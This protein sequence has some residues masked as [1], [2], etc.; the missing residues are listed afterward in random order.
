MKVPWRRC[1]GPADTLA[2]YF[3]DLFSCDDASSFELWTKNSFVDERHH[4]EM[5]TYTH[6]QDS[7]FTVPPRAHPSAGS[8]SGSVRLSRSNFT[9]KVEGTPTS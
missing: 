7:Y 6:S 2:L 1:R 3:R 9:Y 8:P 5:R 4:Y